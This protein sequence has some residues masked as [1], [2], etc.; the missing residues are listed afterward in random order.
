[1]RLLLDEDVP[2]PLLPILRH[3]LR[4]HDVEHVTTQQ[5]RGKKDKPLY[6]DAAAAKFHAVLTND[7]HQF[8]DP[9]ICQAIQRSQLH[10]ISYTLDAGLDGLAMA[11]GAICA[12]IRPLMLDLAVAPNQ[13]IARIQALRKGRKRYEL[14][15][16][17]TDPPSSY[18]P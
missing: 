15:N 17:A 2:E 8:N 3:I 5:W 7:L 6:R 13:R 18:W 4:E 1:M 9:A 16:P 11:T 14:S 10:H 12:A